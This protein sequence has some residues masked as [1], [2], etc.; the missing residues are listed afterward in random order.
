MEHCP[1]C[2][3]EL[4]DAIV[5]CRYCGE[6]LPLQVLVVSEGSRGGGFAIVT[7]KDGLENTGKQEDV[8]NEGSTDA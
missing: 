5:V 3:Q 1:I 6:E 7:G 8:P 2:R 4:R